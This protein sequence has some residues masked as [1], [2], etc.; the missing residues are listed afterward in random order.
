ME[1][2][3][4]QNH[5]IYRIWTHVA[6]THEIKLHL[7][8]CD[9]A[10]ARTKAYCAWFITMPTPENLYSSIRQHRQYACYHTSRER[11]LSHVAPSSYES[12]TAKIP[13]PPTPVSIQNQHTQISMLIVDQNF[14]TKQSFKIQAAKVNVCIN[15]VKKIVLCQD[16]AKCECFFLVPDGIVDWTV[17]LIRSWFVL[18]EQEVPWPVMFL[19]AR[20]LADHLWYAS[21]L[22]EYT[23]KSLDTW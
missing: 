7:N 14:K 6:P 11:T 16:I 15:I 3:G 18:H 22:F 8:N 10:H 9:V 21:D 17:E 20:Q 1:K 12:A 2:K 19:W 13:R 4:K 5:N 23:K